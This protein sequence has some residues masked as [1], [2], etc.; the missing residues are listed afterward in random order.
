MRFLFNT[1][2]Y[3]PAKAGGGPIHSVS[4]LAEELVRRG[5]DVTVVA[6]NLD[7]PGRLAVDTERDYAIDGVKVRYFK[8]RPTV[9]QHWTTM[10]TKAG[11]YPLEPEFGAGWN[12]KEPGST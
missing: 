5:H 4:S 10:F 2:C 12:L 11:V 9:L 7:I 3:K 8:A 6:S 1:V